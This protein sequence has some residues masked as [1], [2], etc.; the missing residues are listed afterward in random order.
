MWFISSSSKSSLLNVM[1]ILWDL[2]ILWEMGSRSA[3]ILW[4][5]VSQCEVWHV[6]KHQATVNSR[7]PR[8]SIKYFEISI[9]RHIR[10]VELRKTINQTTTFKKWICNLTPEVKDI[11]KI[12][13]KS[14]EIAPFSSCPRYSLSVLDF[15]VKTG[16]RF[17]LQD[18]VGQDNEIQLFPLFRG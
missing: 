18:K 17:S 1:K 15:H 3:K 9:P 12:L 7:S 8:D 14:R 13:W 11:L 2:K 16:T 6:W 10:V 4:D 5:F